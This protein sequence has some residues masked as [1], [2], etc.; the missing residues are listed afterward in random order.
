MSGNTSSQYVCI[1]THKGLY[2]YTLLHYCVAPSPAIFQWMMESVLQGIPNVVCYI[3]YI[4][5]AS[6]SDDEHL[7]I[8]WEV[9][10]RLQ[11][12]GIRVQHSKC[13]FLQPS[14]NNCA[15]L[16]IPQVCMQPK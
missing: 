8:L 15:T 10:E 6:K 7:Q 5:I 1:N 9:G 3:D 12:C 13:R 4:H 16:W 2:K 14:S 11:K